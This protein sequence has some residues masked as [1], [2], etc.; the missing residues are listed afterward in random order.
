[1]SNLGKICCGLA[2][3]FSLIAGIFGFLTAKT[4]SGYS[5]QLTETEAATRKFPNLQYNADFKNNPAE[6]A[7]TLTAAAN[8]A[9]KVLEERNGFETELGGTKTKLD[10]ANSQVQKLTTDYTATKKD[11]DEKTAALTK[12]AEELQTSSTELKALKDKLGGRSIDELVKDLDEATEKVKVVSTEKKIVDDAL[13]KMSA[14]LA[15]AKELLDYK[16]EGAAPLDMSGRVV[17]INK[18]WNFVVL[19]VGKDDKLTEGV[20]LTVYR[21]NQLVGKV[22]T[23]DVEN[24]SAI[25]DIIPDLTPMEIQVG[26]KVLY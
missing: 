5:V 7:K 24:K 18:T 9:R 19:D 20:S 8:T 23:V 2:I 12:A 10:E 16:K 25:A 14:E 13:A 21:G 26:D 1:M 6:P 22:R 4:K 11:L 17:A 3:A 15:A